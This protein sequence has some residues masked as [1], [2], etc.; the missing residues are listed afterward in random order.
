MPKGYHHMTQEIRSQI[1]AL[2]STGIALRKIGRIV[3]YDASAISREIKCNTGGR[4]YRY[5][6][7]DAM[8]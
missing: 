8:G 4:G 2:K 6:Q 7:A 3:G 5:K 1:Y